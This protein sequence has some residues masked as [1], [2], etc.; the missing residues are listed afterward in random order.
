M[1]SFTLLP[2]KVKIRK[3]PSSF[4]DFL[5]LLN[6]ISVKR[7]KFK[8]RESDRHGKSRNGHGKVMEKYFVK[9]V[10][11]LILSSLEP[12]LDAYI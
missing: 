5:S 8:I 3:C 11:L 6:G 7:H 9:S 12:C 10:T 1:S 2:S 4:P